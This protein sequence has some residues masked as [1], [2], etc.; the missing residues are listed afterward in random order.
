MQREI[1]ESCPFPVEDLPTGNLLYPLA[2]YR[3]GS[4]CQ[5]DLEHSEDV[6]EDD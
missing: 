6:E 4:E 2:S 1:E 3:Y 5:I